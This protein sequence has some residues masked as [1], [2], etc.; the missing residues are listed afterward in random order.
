MN[1]RLLPFLFLAAALSA[2]A[3]YFLFRVYN[4]PGAA[5]IER[6]SMDSAIKALISIAAVVF[7]WVVTALVYV[8]AFHRRKQ[9]DTSFGA[10][11][12]GNRRLETAWTII[13]LL[14]VIGVSFYGGF[15]L[16][17]ITP[18]AP[19][20][21]LN[22]NVTAFRWG[23]KFYYPDYN[24]NS[25]YI[26]LEVNRQVEFHMASLDVV[27]G[28]WIQAFG[29]K[30][31]IVPGMMMHLDVTPDK[32]GQ[33]TLLCDQLCGAGH[34]GMTA[35]VYV[36]STGDFQTWVTQHKTP[37]A[38]TPPSTSTSTAGQLA[39]LGTTV[40]GADCAS[41]H[42]SAG[43]G[44]IGPRI[45]GAGNAL[46]KYTTAQG[47]LGFIS[48]AMPLNAPGSLSAQQ[49]DELLSFIL[50]QNNWMQAGTVFD[51]NSLSSVPLK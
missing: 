9:G 37:P 45:I 14:V 2:G 38:T 21:V 39:Q 29:P 3:V 12:T 11:I 46:S 13:P 50:V 10:P 43:Q 5:S 16:Q 35:P 27:H 36:V 19:P 4:I 26:E 48:A 40:F 30:Q 47:L 6:G 8:V 23:W 24:V 1:K 51:P 34:T 41:C 49:Y 25:L 22:V 17:K 32:I 28:F 15:V 44:G 31:D 20:G 7:I 42:G 18:S 33:Y